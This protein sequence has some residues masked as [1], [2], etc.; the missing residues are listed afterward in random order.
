MLPKQML[1]VIEGA[2]A[3]GQQTLIT[4]PGATAALQVHH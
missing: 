3:V 2:S 1:E 4:K